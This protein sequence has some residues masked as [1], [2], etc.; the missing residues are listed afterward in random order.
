MES[1]KLDA[2]FKQER[3]I[4]CVSAAS[5]IDYVAVQQLMVTSVRAILVE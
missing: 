4:S 3:I 1:R 5:Q 2:V